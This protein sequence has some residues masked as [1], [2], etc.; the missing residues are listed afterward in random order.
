MNTRN[1]ARYF[2]VSASARVLAT[3]VF[4]L[5]CSV[6]AFGQ[7]VT[8]SIVGTVKDQQGAMITTATVKAINVATGFTRSAPANGYGLYRIDFL[9]VG[10]YS[11]EVVAAGFERFV[12]QNLALDVD[13]TL[14]VDATLTVGAQNLTITVNEAPPAINTSDAVLGKTIEP[15]ELIGL[16]LVNRNVYAELSLTP[17]VMANN[18]SPTSNPSGSPQMTVG[19]ASADV[20][21]NGS[22]DSGNGTVA[23]YLNGG[24]NITGMRNYGNPAPNPDALEEFRVE[25]NAFS[26]QYGQ[27]SGAVIT[28]ITKSGSNKFHG[29]LFEFNRTTDFNAFPWIPSKNPFSPTGAFLKPP[30]HRN[31][32]GG[33]VGGPIKHDK[34]FFFF[35]YAGLRQVQGA[36][37]SG[38]V[39]P[40]AEERMGDFTTAGTGD[41][42]KVYFPKPSG[43]SAA[44]WD[45]PANQIHGTNSSTYCATDTLN[46]IPTALLD[47]VAKNFLNVSNTIG[48]S[49]PLPTGAAQ[50]GSGGGAYLTTYVTP[51]DEDEYLGKFDENMGDKDHVE[52]TYFYSNTASTP[53]GGGNIN[54]TGNQSRSKQTNANISDVHTFS[55]STA[56]QAWL[57]FTRALGGRVLIP[58]TG[59]GNQTLTSFGS[60]FQIQGPAGLPYLN[61]SAGFSTGNPNAGPVTGSNNYELRDVVSMT[62]GKHNLSLGGEFAL[63]QTMFAANLNNYGDLTF[64]TSGATSTSNAIADFITG[65]VNSFE[66]DTTYITHLSTWH[67]A[68]FAQDNYR[69]TPRL[70]ANLGLRWDI[71]TPPVEAHNRTDTFV[72]GQQST[73]TPTAP[74]GQLFVGDKGMYRGIINTQFNHI[75]PRLGVAWDPFGDG[76]TSVRAAAGIF[77]GNP[78]GN[79]WNQPGNAMPFSIRNG[80]GNETSMSY[81][82]D[83]GFPCTAVGTPPHCP[84][85]GGIFPYTFTPTAPKFYPSQSIEAIGPNFKDSSVYQFNLSVQRQLPYKISVTTAYVGTLGRHL[86]TFIDANYAPYSTVANGGGS[87]GTAGLSTSAASTEQRRQWDAGANLAAGTLS[88]ITYLISDQTSNYNGLQISATKTMSRGFSLSGFY[89]WSRALESAEFVENGGQGAQNFGY[90]GKPFTAAN[91]HGMLDQNSNPIV[92]GGLGEEKGLMNNNRDGNAAIY[93]IWNINY[94]RGSNQIAK[95]AANGWSITSAAYFQSGLPFSVSTGSDK[96]FD[97]A[98]A[99]RPDAVPGV[100]PK[101][102]PHRCR[103]CGATG[104]S[105]NSVVTQWF[106]A[107]YSAANTT[108]PLAQAAGQAFIA[109]GPG[110]PGGIGPGGADGNVGRNS[111]IGPGLKDMDAGLLRDVRLPRGTVFQFRAEITNVMNWV[112]LNNP[113]SGNITATNQGTITSAAGTQR[114]IQLGG[115]LTF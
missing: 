62:K 88:G 73:I 87:L 64:S 66:Q 103:V 91:D 33:T 89:V 13:Q 110:Q 97:T 84:A 31:N 17:G 44:V 105:Q 100:S 77:Y 111:L 70:T 99:N 37:V 53:S 46:C 11:I 78:A 65:Q 22:L 5:T 28:V 48:V 63:D 47:P 10:K 81:I 101:L 109:N 58:V 6:I 7:Q 3:L 49:V 108:I 74:L 56:N 35:S 18:M 102:G 12:Q 113:N 4:I 67:T 54:W 60:N 55:P 16:P 112:S 36:P 68:V 75:S 9:P 25:T 20:Q 45:V 76:K 1:L 8:G 2:R 93:G 30:F 21:V 19:I 107:T 114:I 83:V 90:F 59:P 38:G 26:A 79:E 34:A 14:T 15:D 71:D 40:T 27:F 23:F 82:Y 92:G 52:V 32:F 104:Q 29:S 43:T 50:T 57:T 95:V 39:T 42:F 61:V 69:I 72:P 98:N 94:Y 115:R 106:N 80:F 41:T 51:T 86:S 85:G 24:N 96:T